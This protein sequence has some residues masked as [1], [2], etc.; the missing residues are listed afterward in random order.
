MSL[1]EEERKRI[2]AHLDKLASEEEN[3][4]LDSEAKNSKELLDEI[5]LQRKTLSHLEAFQKD[6]MKS[7]MLADYRKVQAESK[8]SRFTSSRVIWYAAAS[9]VL[10]TSI[11][12]LLRNYISQDKESIFAK[13]YQPYDG[14]SI[15]RDGST[16]FTAGINAYYD[17]NYAEALNIFR[18]STN[19]EIS[20]GELNLLIASCLISLDQSSQ[21][22]TYLDKMADTE[23]ELISNNK[24]WYLALAYLK[25]G[26]VDRSRRILTDIIENNSPFSSSASKLLNEEIYK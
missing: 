14:V 15:T 12:F 7:E 25:I 13:Y 26:N 24:E 16:K 4:S 21:A 11:T 18:N 22:I 1:S 10:I 20:E 9:V 2:E 6:K 3:D 23:A 17:K 19:T 5:S 8:N